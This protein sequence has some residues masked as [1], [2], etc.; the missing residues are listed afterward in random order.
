MPSKYLVNDRVFHLSAIFSLCGPVVF[1]FTDIFATS[2]STNYN[3]VS[4]SISDLMLTRYGWIEKL[5]IIAITIPL[6]LLF[7][8]YTFSKNRELKEKYVSGFLLGLTAICFILIITFDTDP[9]G[10]N[11]SL[12]GRIHIIAAA[13]VSILFPVTCFLMAAAWKKSTKSAVLV[14]YAL[15]TGLAGIT[16][17]IRAL[18]FFDIPQGL[19][20]R[21]LTLVNLVWIGTL[22]IHSRLPILDSRRV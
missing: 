22:G 16:E 10:F 6:L 13:L 2:I 12:R 5:G 9:G 19:T 17:M 3:P 8:Q 21:C 14:V 4:Q 1:I 20:Q 18:N 15:A 7:F 11:S